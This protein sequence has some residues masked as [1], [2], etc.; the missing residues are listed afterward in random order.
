MSASLPVAR[1]NYLT[2]SG[3]ATDHGIR[4]GHGPVGWLLGSPALL[5]PALRPIELTALALQARADMK[6]QDLKTVA[7]LSQLK[8]EVG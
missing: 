1:K 5:A 2:I 6:Q 3:W 8:N 7:R 4:V